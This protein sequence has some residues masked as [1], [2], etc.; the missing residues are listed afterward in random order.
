MEAA[1]VRLNARLRRGQKPP[2][3]VDLGSI[4]VPDS[5]LCQSASEL[6]ASVSEP[7]LV[8]HCLRTFLWAAILGKKGQHRFDEELLFVASALHDLGLTSAR[9]RLTP[10]NAECFAVEGAFAAEEFLAEHGLDHR[11]QEVV[12]EAISLHLNVR[13][14]LAHGMEAHLLHEGAALDVVGARF[15]E[16]AATTRNEVLGVHPRLE[17][18]SSLVAAM[19]QQSNMRPRSRAGFLCGHGFISMIRHA[20]FDAVEQCS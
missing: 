2:F 18:K 3:S 12:A 10:S 16:V 14:S 15:D 19:K 17:M 11:R 1:L 8:N 6:L 9:A 20:P 5:G 7:W 4:R 13:V